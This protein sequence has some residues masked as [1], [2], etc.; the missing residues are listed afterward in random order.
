MDE[1]EL[2]RHFL[3]MASAFFQWNAGNNI[4]NI[5]RSLCD[6][7]EGLQ[8]RTREATDAVIDFHDTVVKATEASSRLATA[9]N[10]FTRALVIV[11]AIGLIM[12]GIYIG[13]VIWT[14]FNP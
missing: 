5:L 14:H 9:L 7:V 1:D 6:D 11:G 10:G 8:M 2:R 4:P 3:I 13:F 12:Q